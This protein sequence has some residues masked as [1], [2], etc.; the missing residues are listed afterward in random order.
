MAYIS[1]IIHVTIYFPK[2][3]NDLWNGFLT[4]FF[5]VIPRYKSFPMK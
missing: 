5:G 1:Q 2:E 4:L 3:R